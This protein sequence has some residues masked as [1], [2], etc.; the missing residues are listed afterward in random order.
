MVVLLGIISGTFLPIHLM[1]KFIQYLSYVSPIR[2]GI[3]NYLN[4]FIREGNIASILPNT[5]LLILF[6][7]FAM[8]TSIAIFAKQK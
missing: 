8:I 3:D 2:W 4:L 5:I 6:F 1:P 7:G